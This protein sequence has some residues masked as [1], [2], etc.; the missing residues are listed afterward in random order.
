MAGSLRFFLISIVVL[1][2]SLNIY[3]NLDKICNFIPKDFSKDIFKLYYFKVN[4][5]AA[6][7]RAL[8]SCSKVKFENNYIDKNNWQEQKKNTTLFE[9]GQ[10]P[11]LVHND[12]ILSQSKAIYVYLARLFNLYGKTIDD[13]YQIDSLLSSSDDISRYSG[14]VFF[15]RTDEEKNNPEKYKEIFKKELKRF[16]GIYEQRY[17]KLGNGKYFLGNYFSLADIYLTI[18][19]DILSKSVGGLQYIKESAPKLAELIE[20]IKNNELKEFFEK[21]YL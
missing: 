8:F 2:L 4:G 14:P 17:K 9:F 11:I 5:R 15:P 20:R 12:K 1:I 6:I 18:N 19:M 10:V 21:Y 13:K 16:L 7:I 3:L